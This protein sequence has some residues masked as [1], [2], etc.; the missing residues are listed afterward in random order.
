MATPVQVRP[1]CQQARRTRVAPTVVHV[2]MKALAIVATGPRPAAPL[3]RIMGIRRD[4]YEVLRIGAKRVAG[5]RDVCHQQEPER[6][7]LVGV[8][9][10]G[11]EPPR[12][13]PAWSAC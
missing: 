2:Y 6:P 10:P 5:R 12:S 4:Q 3:A 8:S 9:F 13:S 11:V 1:E 7:N